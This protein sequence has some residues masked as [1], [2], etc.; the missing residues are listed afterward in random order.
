MYGQTSQPIGTHQSVIISFRIRNLH[1]A[2]LKR[3]T[4]D[5]RKKKRRRKLDG[6]KQNR[7]EQNG[8]I[9]VN[10]IEEQRSKG[11][12]DERYNLSLSLSKDTAA[13]AIES[14]MTIPLQV[15]V[16]L[17]PSAAV[18][19]LRLRP[20]HP[21]QNCGGCFVFYSLMTTTTMVIIMI[22]IVLLQ[23]C[24]G[25]LPTTVTNQ[26]HFALSSSS[27]SPPCHLHLTERRRRG[28]TQRRTLGGAGA[29]SMSHLGLAT[30]SNESSTD[31]T[32]SSETTTATTTSSATT[33]T[34]TTTTATNDK[35]SSKEDDKTDVASSASTKTKT[36]TTNDDGK[37]DAENATSTSSSSSLSTM[38]KAEIMSLQQQAEQLRQEAKQMTLKIQEEKQAKLIKEQTKIDTWIEELLINTKVDDTTELLNTIDQVVTKLTQDRYSQE[39]INKIFQRICDTSEEIGR[40]QSRSNLSP[41]MEL[42]VDSVGKMD[43]I[44]RKDQENKRW[45]TGK[46][47]RNLRKK[48]FAL[49]WNI[50][51]RDEADDD[52]N[53]PW[54]L[55]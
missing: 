32:S 8:N 14:T 21:Q 38:S 7:T 19:R 20:R 43:E 12:K 10:I 33:T 23:R 40:R 55:R 29:F 36:T 11:T 15:V 9:I 3:K 39:Q 2:L 35:S 50:K 53:N 22:V 44:D 13:T 48:L 41:I 49:D 42:F 4:K 31:T 25:Y 17:P 51:L 34:T 5:Q 6:K 37:F 52:K 47:E 54:N 26:Q 16:Q 1:L 46:V 18:L 28:T 24:D 27:L 30:S 45:K